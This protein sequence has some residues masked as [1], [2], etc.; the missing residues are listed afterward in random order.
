MLVFSAPL[1]KAR[2][3]LDELDLLRKENKNR[4][5]EDCKLLEEVICLEL[6]THFNS[7]VSRLTDKEYGSEESLQEAK[8]DLIAQMERC[9]PFKNQPPREA[10]E[11]RLGDLRLPNDQLVAKYETVASSQ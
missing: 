6:R 9:V 7:L 10:L 11:E 5:D 4:N 3:W 1:S 2:K 8:Q